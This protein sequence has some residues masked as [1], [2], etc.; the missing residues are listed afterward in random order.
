MTLI[1]NQDQVGS[2]LEPA[3]TGTQIAAGRLP[4]TVASAPQQDLLAPL[5]RRKYVIVL[6][7][8]VGA[9]LGYLA[10][11]NAT[12]MYQSTTRLMIWAQSPPIALGEESIPQQIS[13]AKYEN[14][15]GSR[16]V[17]G[18]AVEDANLQSTETVAVGGNAAVDKLRSLIAIS[19]SADDRNTDDS[20]ALTMRGP[21]P[22]ELPGIIKNITDSF[23][24]EIEGNT[25]EA[26]SES[27]ELIKKLEQRLLDEKQVKEKRYLELLREMGV[28]ERDESG[29]VVNPLASQLSEEEGRL[30]QA[31]NSLR[32]ISNRITQLKIAME[33]KNPEA[34]RICAIEGRDFLNIESKAG[35]LLG[36]SSRSRADRVYATAEQQK[37]RRISVLEAESMAL[38]T[39]LLDLASRID[40]TSSKLG[41]QHIDLRMLVNSRERLLLRKKEISEEMGKMLVSENDLMADS[42]D[43][44]ISARLGEWSDLRAKEEAE[45][46][47]LYRVALLRQQV[48]LTAEIADMNRG[49][50]TI[51][52]EATSKARD[53]DEINLLKT[54][55]DENRA[56]VGA[57]LES[58]PK[59]D[60][61]FSSYNT[62][63]VRVVDPPQTGLQ[64]APSIF[65]YIG[66]G[67]FLASLLGCGLALLIDRADHSFRSPNEIVEIFNAPVRSRIPKSLIL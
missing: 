5:M 66:I 64:V 13:L 50:A 61:L 38:E 11:Q 20:I 53:V 26:G 48:S 49:I 52:L 58:L 22:E 19:S 23:I 54:Q 51:R 24:K 47:E 18:R 4:Q 56:Q 57:I 21:A 62:V 55:I 30:F 41:R 6:F 35:I 36:G 8:I 43:S 42:V 29:A 12:P 7:A 14:L 34:I 37:L 2:P 3:R 59:L 33:S 67:L 27:L 9:S 25:K 31:E 60:V 65:R 17:L 32:D 10:F 45:W 39:R 1:A 28:V 44:E 40:Q 16:V 15:L 63:R 46:L